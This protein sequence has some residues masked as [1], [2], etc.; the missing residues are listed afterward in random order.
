MMHNKE[1]REMKFK[2]IGGNGEVDGELL[3]PPSGSLSLKS[4]PSPN[5][6]GLLTVKDKKNATF[7]EHQLKHCRTLANREHRV[8]SQPACSHRTRWY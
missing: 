4:R 2:D 8:T 5:S 6:F 3:P 7:K 1:K